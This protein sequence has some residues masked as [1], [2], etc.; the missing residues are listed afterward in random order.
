M[1]CSRCKQGVVAC[2][3]I[4]CQRELCKSCAGWGCCARNPAVTKPY[5]PG[6]VAPKVSPPPPP[7]PRK[8]RL[9]E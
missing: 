8:G 5:Y 3:C 7:P 2:E 4:H 6:G 9:Q 1:I